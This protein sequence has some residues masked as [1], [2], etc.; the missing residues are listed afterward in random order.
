M[1]GDNFV[2]PENLSRPGRSQ[3]EESGRTVAEA[4]ERALAAL[5]MSRGD[6][7][8]EVLDEGSRGVLG[9]GA[10]E[11]RV[12]VRGKSRVEKLAVV[13]EVAGSIVTLMGFE[14]AIKAEEGLESVHVAAD[15]ENLAALIGK[16]GQTLGALETLVALIAGR[17]LGIPI[18]VEMDVLGYRERRRSALEA[19][20]QRVAERVAKSGREVA[21]SPMA[22]R[23]RRIVHLTLQDHSRVMTSSRG[24][25]ELR[26]VVVVPKERARPSDE[27]RPEPPSAQRAPARERLQP[28]AEP[29]DNR[30]RSGNTP[31]EGRAERTRNTNYSGKWTAGGRI[32]RFQER[33]PQRGGRGAAGSLSRRTPGRGGDRSVGKRPEGLPVDEELE[34]EIQAHLESHLVPDRFEPAEDPG[35]AAEPEEHPRRDGKPD[36]G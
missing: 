5:G 35:A 3:A 7:E 22:P 9:I 25:G 36:E 32:G 20:A 6:V 17:R 31:A 4:V 19:L 16:H 29:R 13:Q 30:G 27:I 11:A 21:L 1:S 8:V 2:D 15:G 18:R 34:A 14:A 33:T 12:R 28:S 24:E 26:R 10:R 23:D